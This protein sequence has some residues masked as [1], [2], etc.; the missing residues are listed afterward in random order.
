MKKTNVIFMAF[1]IAM[2]FSANAFAKQGLSGGI[3]FG[4]VGDAASMGATILTDGLDNAA[5]AHAGTGN[6]TLGYDEVVLI[7]AENGLEDQQT[8]GAITDLETSGVM[9]A[10][11]I[12]AKVRYDISYFFAELKFN[13]AFKIMGGDT[14]WKAAGVE[15]KQEWSYN[16]WAIP[17]VLGINIPVAEGKANIYAGLQLGYMSGSWGVD[18]TRTYLSSTTGALQAG[19]SNAMTLL[20]QSKMEEEIKF[21]ASGLG[22]GYVIGVDAEVYE[23]ISLFFE[24]DSMTCAAMDEYKVKDAVLNAVGVTHFNYPAVIGGT[25]LNLG[26]KYHIL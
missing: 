5:D 25:S 18:V 26:V 3:G 22:I 11:K 7:E 14:T 6:Q 4:L 23:N 1:I 16:A 19:V 9:S 10:L 20:G 17:V 8:A 21:E 15:Q 13:Y 12:D 2:A 24:I